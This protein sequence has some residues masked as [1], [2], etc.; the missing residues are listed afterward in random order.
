MLQGRQLRPRSFQG[1]DCTLVVSSGCTLSQLCSVGDKGTTIHQEQPGES[2]GVETIRAQG[3]EGGGVLGSSPPLTPVMG[4]LEP[5]QGG[6]GCQAQIQ[7]A[8]QPTRCAFGPRLAEV[9]TPPG[10][11]IDRV[12]TA[13]RSV[14]WDCVRHRD[15]LTRQSC[16]V[17]GNDPILQKRT[18]AVPLVLG[19]TGRKWGVP[20]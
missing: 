15:L 12:K 9:P 18:P 2:P 10:V 17:S 6:T 8:K 19:H 20:L 16:Q 7:T 13:T 3:S 14:V 4:F 5:T 11:T 1:A